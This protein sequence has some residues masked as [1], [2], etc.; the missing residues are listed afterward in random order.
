MSITSMIF[1]PRTAPKPKTM[2]GKASVPAAAVTTPAPVA[3]QLVLA[4]LKAAP[5]DIAGQ[6]EVLEVAI[7]RLEAQLNTARK[8]V[9]AST[10]TMSG[11]SEGGTGDSAYWVSRFETLRT[12]GHTAVKNIKIA[13]AERPAP[14]PVEGPGSQA[15]DQ[16]AQLL[17]LKKR[18]AVLVDQL[19]D[20][21][22]ALAQGK[23]ELDAQASGGT[24]DV[25]YWVRRFKNLRS[26]GEP[27]LTGLKAILDAG[28]PCQFKPE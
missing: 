4:G 9:A 19:N 28:S 17:A 10:K 3:D 25:T 26:A 27:M 21:R 2:A 24:G 16:P 22:A 7:A 1:Q 23:D 8:V 20:A 14:Q 6:I 15:G 12:G 13:L 18:R 11:L 5:R